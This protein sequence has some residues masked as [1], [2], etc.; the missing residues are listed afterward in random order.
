MISL[1]AWR[2][3]YRKSGVPDQRFMQTFAWFVVEN[4]E[5]DVPAICPRTSS[6]DV[7]VAWCLMAYP[8]MHPNYDRKAN[9]RGGIV[10]WEWRAMSSNSLP[11]YDCIANWT[12]DR[13]EP[14]SAHVS[15]NESYVRPVGVGRGITWCFDWLSPCIE[16]QIRACNSSSVRWAKFWWEDNFDH[17]LQIFVASFTAIGW[18][19]NDSLPSAS[20]ARIST[21]LC[22]RPVL[23]ETTVFMAQQQQ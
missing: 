4:D 10:S 13:C 11:S 9:R 21:A 3:P 15:C 17:S 6:V 8:T 5:G 22:L 14:L 19:R 7:S 18:G 20:L 1:T 2:W 12:S 23:S 16:R